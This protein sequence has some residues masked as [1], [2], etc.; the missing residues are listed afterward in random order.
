MS[1]DS[2]AALRVVSYL[3]LPYS[4]LSSLCVV[5]TPIRD[6]VYDY[7]AKQRYEWF[8]KAED[9][10]VLQEKELLERFIDREELMNRDWDS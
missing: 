7:V 3:P 4:V 6:A 5:P 8:G 1:Y 10:L 9:C 2:A